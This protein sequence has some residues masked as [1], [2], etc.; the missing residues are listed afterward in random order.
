MIGEI[1]PFERRYIPSIHLVN[2]VENLGQEVMLNIRTYVLG[3][4]FADLDTA[5]EKFDRST[6]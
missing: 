3:E 2:E 1:G 5:K 6:G 4:S